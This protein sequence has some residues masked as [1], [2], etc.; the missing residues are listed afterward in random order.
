M[1]EKQN[2]Y[3][4]QKLKASQLD[5]MEDG[6]IYAQELAENAQVKMNIE[7][8][9]VAGSIQQKGFIMS[10]GDSTLGAIASGEGAVAFGGQRFDKVGDSIEE[11]PQTE[12]KGKQ[13]FAAGGGVIVG[14][15]WSTGFGKDTKTFLKGCFAANG[16]TQ[17]GIT[18]ED[19]LV[20]F[21]KGADSEANQIEFANAYEKDYCFAS[22]FGDST[23]ALARAATSLGSQTVAKGKSSLA[24]GL[25]SVT[26]EMGTLAG[27]WDSIAKSRYGIVYGAQLISNPNVVSQVVFGTRNLSTQSAFIIGDGADLNNRKNIFEVRK[28]GDICMYYNGKMYSLQKIFASLGKFVEACEIDLSGE[29]TE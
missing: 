14:G 28:N 9:A 27:G 17:A 3:S 11:E 8:G 10:T 16:G 25:G 19:W 26:E 23:K 29:V 22:A 18:Y 2:F 1:Y 21:N 15:D 5:A 24:T 4:G 13:S 7:D 20:T 6:I 12:A